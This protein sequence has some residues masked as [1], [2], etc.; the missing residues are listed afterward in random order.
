MFRVDKPTDLSA[1][2]IVERPAGVERLLLLATTGF[3][4][5]SPVATR[6]SLAERSAPTDEQRAKLG[7]LA[8]LFDDAKVRQRASVTF[9]PGDIATSSLEY[10]VVEAP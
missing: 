2:Y 7:L 10:T 5:L 9:A 8:P 4:D 1:L 6:G 3:T